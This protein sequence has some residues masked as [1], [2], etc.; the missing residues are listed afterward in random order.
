ME[1]TK[2]LETETILGFDF[3]REEEA[4]SRVVARREDED[5]VKSLAKKR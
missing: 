5:V 3:N 4:V 2:V 1:V